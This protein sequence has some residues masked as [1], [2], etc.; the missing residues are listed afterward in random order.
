[1]MTSDLQDVVTS[2]MQVRSLESAKRHA[3]MRA[4]HTIPNDIQDKLDRLDR[5]FALRVV[6]NSDPKA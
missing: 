4:D 2:F 5:V 6:T 3:L 1:M